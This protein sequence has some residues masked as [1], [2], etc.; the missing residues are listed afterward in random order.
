LYVSLRTTHRDVN[1]G[2]I[3]QAVLGS[4]HAGGHDMIAGGRIGVPQHGSWEDV[5]DGV[6]TRLLEAIGASDATAAVLVG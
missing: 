2:A 6:R 4:D 5:A 3:L 1:A